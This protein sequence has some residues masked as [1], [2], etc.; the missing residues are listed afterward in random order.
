MRVVSLSR[1][2]ISEIKTR[3]KIRSLGSEYPNAQWFCN[4][5]AEGPSPRL[6]N[7]QFSQP[8][9]IFLIYG[10]IIYVFSMYV[11]YTVH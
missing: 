5:V 11:D 3:L 9:Q 8:R 10:N 6:E 2:E 7:Y 4:V 1:R